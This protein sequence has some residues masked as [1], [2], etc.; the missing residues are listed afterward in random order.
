[1]HCGTNGN[2]LQSR[3]G[4]WITCFDGTSVGNSDGAIVGGTL[5][6]LLGMTVGTTVGVIVGLKVGAADESGLDV[7]ISHSSS[8]RMLQSV[9]GSMLTLGSSVG[10]EVERRLGS[11]DGEAVG[12]TVGVNEGGCVGGKDDFA[13][14]LLLGRIV[15]ETEL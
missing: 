12:S 1:M 13:E 4:S 3:T 15:G 7:R 5:G 9:Y 10:V 8:V 14:G 6:D 2:A 11:S